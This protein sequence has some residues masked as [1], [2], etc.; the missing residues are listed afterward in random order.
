MINPDSQIRD[1]FV[2]SS[3]KISNINQ[4]DKVLQ[5]QSS[6]SNSNNVT[7]DIFQSQAS[8][9]ELL[10]QIDQ[11]ISQK[12]DELKKIEQEIKNMENDRVKRESV[13]DP[14]LKQYLESIDQ[15]KLENLNMQ[16]Q[17]IENQ[18]NV[19]NSRKQQVEQEKLEEERNIQKM[20]QMLKNNYDISLDQLQNLRKQLESYQ[21]STNESYKKQIEALN[22][23]IKV[24][25]KEID[26]LLNQQ[27]SN[28]EEAEQIA[29]KIKEKRDLI[30][31]LKGQIDLASADIAKINSEL[32]Q[33][34]QSLDSQIADMKKL[35]MSDYYQ[36]W[37]MDQAI[38]REVENIIWGEMLNE[39]N[40]V[41]NR[42]KMYFDT[43][44]K[45]ASIWKDMYFKKVADESDFV[46]R[47]SAALGR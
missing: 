45:I 23:Q 28:P 42:W 20:Q 46:S 41:A 26:D 47:W 40:H 15:I 9:E 14:N 1:N 18:L 29:Q 36:K 16:K 4:K 6:D 12:T 10:K 33:Q 25:Q 17:S 37:A 7:N 3:V 32:N 30:S 22:N 5:D 38:R 24:I 44:Q 19:L 11:L 34:I 31:T 13:Q 27:P 8:K 21:S 43:N 2:N 35:K 39:K